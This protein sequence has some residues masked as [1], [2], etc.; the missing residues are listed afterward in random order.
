M[1]FIPHSA[2]GADRQIG[3]INSSIKLGIREFFGPNIALFCFFLFS[4]RWL[5]PVCPPIRCLRLTIL[6]FMF[7]ELRGSPLVLLRRLPYDPYLLF[8]EGREDVRVV[9]A[10]LGLEIGQ[11]APGMAMITRLRCQKDLRR[12][13]VEIASRSCRT[14]LQ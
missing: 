8:V 2:W 5:G 4:F 13:R 3:L 10:L 6:R 12:S 1:P 11:V 14:A 7:G 9:L